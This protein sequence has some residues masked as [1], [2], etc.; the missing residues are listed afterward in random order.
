MIKDPAQR[1]T[2]PKGKINKWETPKDAALRE[3]QEETGLH[4]LKI[5]CELGKI[6]YFY[7][8]EKKLIFKIVHHFLIETSDKQLYPN[9]EV[10]EARWFTI[11]ETLD[12]IG[13]KNNKMILKKAL[14]KLKKIAAWEGYHGG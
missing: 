9:Y 8:Q 6:R 4:N 13:Y 3:I 14:R 12:K 2:F 11:Q 7:R 5:V 10:K 1:W